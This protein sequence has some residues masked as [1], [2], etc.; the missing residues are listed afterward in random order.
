MDRNRDKTR[1]AM[2][3]WLLKLGGGYVEVHYTVLV[4]FVFIQSNK[5]KTLIIIKSLNKKNILQK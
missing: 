1:L 2:S 4:N 3:L 5:V